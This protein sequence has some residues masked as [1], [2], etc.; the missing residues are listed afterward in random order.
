L[1]YGLLSAHSRNPFF[2]FS[3]FP[4]VPAPPRTCSVDLPIQRVS[5]VEELQKISLLLV[6]RTFPPDVRAEVFG[7]KPFSSRGVPFSAFFS[8][9]RIF[10]LSS[11]SRSSRRTASKN[12]LPDV[13]EEKN[14]VF[15]PSRP[16]GVKGLL[17]GGTKGQ[18]HSLPPAPATSWHHTS[19]SPR[20]FPPLT[21][22]PPSSFD[23]APSP[24]FSPTRVPPPHQH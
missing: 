8:L 11:D 5:I 24:H 3:G 2:S 17:G 10:S 23:R 12:C 13:E 9:A 21:L 4:Y 14:E 22:P 15:S 19:M 20:P 16:L 1:A 6:T 18:I 7:V